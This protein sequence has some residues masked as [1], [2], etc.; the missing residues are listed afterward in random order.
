METGCDAI[1]GDF[2]LTAAGKIVCIH[3]YDT[4]RVSGLKKSAKESTLADPRLKT[5]QSVVTSFN[6]RLIEERFLKLG[7]MSTTTNRPGFQKKA[8]E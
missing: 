1:E 3:D 6:A 4:K 8:G 5:E 2:H 7:A